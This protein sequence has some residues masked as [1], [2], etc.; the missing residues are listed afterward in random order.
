M[1][2]E[3]DGLLLQQGA[4]GVGRLYDRHGRAVFRLAFAL[5]RNPDDANDVVQDTFLL[6][7]R[8]RKQITLLAGS[9][10]PW[11]LTTARLTALAARRRRDARASRSAQLERADQ[12]PRSA[13]ADADAVREALAGLPAPDRAVLTL[14]LVEDRSYADAAQQLGISI[15]AVGKRLQR[16]RSKFRRSYTDPSPHPQG[17]DS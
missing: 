14:V 17:A 16:A 7:W 13:F 10:L 1:P 9:S 4:D 15:T 12:V 3:D 11:L 8:K 6:A 2:N 5:L